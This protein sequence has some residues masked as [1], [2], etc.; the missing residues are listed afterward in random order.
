MP[1]EIQVAPPGITISQGRT[2]MVTD[3]RGEI[4]PRCDQGVYAIDT[5]FIS[6]Y[7][8]FINRK[9]WVLVNASQLNFYAARFYLTNPKISAQAGDFEAH[10]IGLM[11]DRRVEDDI[12]EDFYVVNYTG[13]RISLS[14][15]LS[16]RSDF[17]DLFDSVGELLCV[18]SQVRSGPYPAHS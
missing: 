9:P 5:R 4:N 15:Q 12:H 1:L 10:T 16:L 3:E 17:A 6:Y 11:I 7:R 2:F 13:K 18:S 8:F 14:L